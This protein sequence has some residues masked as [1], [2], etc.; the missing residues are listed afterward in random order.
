MPFWF[1]CSQ[2]FHL[3]F[4][5]LTCSCQYSYN[6]MLTTTCMYWP[7]IDTNISLY[8]H[9]IGSR[10]YIVGGKS[11]PRAPVLLAI[12]FMPFWF[13]CSQSFNLFGF[14]NF[15][16]WAP[17]DESYSRN[18]SCAL[19]CRYRHRCSWHGL[20]PPPFFFN[21]L[22]TNLFSIKFLYLFIISSLF[23]YFKIRK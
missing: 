14:P 19:R 11:V 16:L 8:G 7:Y 18:V 5:I 21:F 9:Y 17:P 6:L 23:P 3:F 13:Y 12:L 1:Y 20:T 2:R 4:L 10:I 22:F 15:R